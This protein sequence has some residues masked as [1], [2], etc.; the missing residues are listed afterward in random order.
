MDTLSIQWFNVQGLYTGMCTTKV[1]GGV[2]A[3]ITK[4]WWLRREDLCRS[5]EKIIEDVPM[6]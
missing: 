4:M 1:A 5:L 6:N 2:H 3:A